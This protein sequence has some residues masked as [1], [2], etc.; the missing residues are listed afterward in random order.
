MY[1][2]TVTEAAARVQSRDTGLFGDVVAAP[3]KGSAGTAAPAAVPNVKTTTPLVEAVPT[4]P[5]VPVTRSAQSEV[6]LFRAPTPASGNAPA[7]APTQAPTVPLD[8]VDVEAA[9]EFLKTFDPT[10]VHHLCYFPVDGGAPTGRAFPPGAWEDVRRFLKDAPPGVNHYFSVNEPSVATSKAKCAKADIARIRAVFLDLDLD[11]NKPLAEAREDVAEKVEMLRCLDHPPVLVV[12]SGGGKHAYWL[13]Q[14]KLPATD[15]L[16]MAEGIGRSAAHA[17][18]ADLKTFNA[19]RILALPGTIKFPDAKKREYGR[20]PEP[21][22]VVHSSPR[23]CR[24]AELEAQFPP[25]ID[26]AVTKSSREDVDALVQSWQSLALESDANN[27]VE[28]DDLDRRFTLARL[29]DARLDALARHDA[30]GLLKPGDESGSAWHYAL[31]ARLVEHGFGDDDFPRLCKRLNLPGD[32]P[33][34]YDPN[35]YGGAVRLARAWLNAQAAGSSYQAR[36]DAAND[37][38]LWLDMDADGTKVPGTDAGNRSPVDGTADIFGDEDPED[39]FGDEDPADRV[40]PPPGSMPRVIERWVATEAPRKR[41][42]PAAAAACAVSIAGAAVGNS[43]QIQVRQRDTGWTEPATLWVVLLTESGSG[44]SPI[45]KEATKPLRAADKQKL[46]ASK[47]NLAKWDENESLRKRAKGESRPPAYPKPPSL[48]HVVDDI[49]TERLLEIQRDNPRGVHRSTD[50]YVA[51]LGSLGAYKRGG[52]SADRGRMLTMF[53][54]GCV[55]V[56][57]KGTGD[58]IADSALLSVLSGSQPDKLRPMVTELGSDGMLQRTLFIMDDGR[59]W[60]EVDEAPDHEAIHDYERIIRTLA[61]ADYVL[62]S[63]VR[64]TE[65]AYAE[66]ADTRNKIE[67]L[68]YSLG[69]SRAFAG[70]IAKWGKILPRIL[71]IFHAVEQVSAHGRVNPESLVDVSTVKMAS[72]FARFLLRHSWAFYREYYGRAEGT[73]DAHWYADYILTHPETLKISHRDIGQAKKDWR[74]DGHKRLRLRM[75]GELERGGWVRVATRSQGEPATWDVNPR[76]H[77][78]FA[79]RAVRVA[80]ERVK[81]RE[82]IQAAKVTRGWIKGDVTIASASVSTNSLFE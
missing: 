31:A 11:K 63:C 51:L 62:P 30:A 75:M 66:L 55:S 68:A 27:V 82:L 53:D 35:E 78:R 6:T 33:E 43:L 52:A 13:L 79:E 39:I 32:H 81:T 1:T 14:E 40:D 57:R 67:Q 72:L 19:D 8:G 77:V 50:E 73:E 26:A 34:R 42:A 65:A 58:M 59:N 15:A 47:I 37:P 10:G 23:R 20:G 80:R 44:K 74:G 28:F 22:A 29:K 45:I 3:G 71:L 64:L 70:H 41:V 7:P 61:E 60:P 16:A 24:L 38:T 46:D 18:G 5:P 56:E 9:I 49:T 21:V 25:S 48:R 54:G 4:W 17:I 12:H 2:H 69:A 36:R 76:V